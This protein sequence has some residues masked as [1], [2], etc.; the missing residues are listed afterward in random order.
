MK[1]KKQIFQERTRRMVVHRDSPQEPVDAA[2][3]LFAE[4]QRLAS[5]GHPLAKRM[6]WGMRLAAA[7]LESW[8]DAACSTRYVKLRPH[9]P[10][11]DRMFDPATAP[12]SAH[13]VS[14]SKYATDP[15]GFMGKQMAKI[16]RER[17]AARAELASLEPTHRHTWADACRVVDCEANQEWRLE[18][19]DCGSMREKAGTR[20]TTESPIPD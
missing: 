15:V 8:G 12:E 10:S 2:T 19:C 1:T 14:E 3:M 17:D 13:A 20:V 18:R 9:Q 11:Q 6:A 16:E 7:K 5:L 4:S